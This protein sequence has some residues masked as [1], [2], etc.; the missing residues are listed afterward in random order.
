MESDARKGVAMKQRIV[1]VDDGT[2]R[3]K[4]LLEGLKDGGYDVIV[5]ENDELSNLCDTVKHL[6]PQVL[7]LDDDR[8]FH[9]K[10]ESS[11]AKFEAA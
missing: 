5:I 9:F 2:E 4:Y 1:V 6:Q 7:M 8:I 11:Y 10:N 3:T